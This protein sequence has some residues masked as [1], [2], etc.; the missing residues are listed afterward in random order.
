[1]E[2]NQTTMDEAQAALR[3]LVNMAIV[4][5]DYCCKSGQCEMRDRASR[6][7]SHLAMAEAEAGAMKI[8][9]PEGTVTTRDGG[10]GGGG[11]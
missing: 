10:G 8:V 7:L 5:R 11:K 1:M 9:T 2:I 3:H 4:A 6:V